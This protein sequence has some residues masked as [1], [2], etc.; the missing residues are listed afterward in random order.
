MSEALHLLA[1]FPLQKCLEKKERNSNKI[2]KNWYIKSQRKYQVITL[3]KFNSSPLK[4]Y[5]TPRSERLVF[6]P[7]FF[8]GYV[9]TWGCVTPSSKSNVLFVWHLENQQAFQ[10]SGCPLPCRAARRLSDLVVARYTG[11]ATWITRHWWH[12]DL[13][14]MVG[15]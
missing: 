4:S 11:S 1:Q 3:P 15:K 2:Y 7:P 14:G 5:R 12:W 6:Q 9:R 8:K 10:L 13:F